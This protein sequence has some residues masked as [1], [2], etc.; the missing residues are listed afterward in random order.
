MSYVH[1][2][3]DERSKLDEKSKKCVFVRY[4]FDDFGY[5]FFDLDQRKLI[6]SRVVIFMEDY[7]IGDIDKVENIDPIFKDEEMVDTY[8]TTITPTSITF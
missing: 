2:P 6:C 8:S 4:G 3:K 7:T 1:I 5:R